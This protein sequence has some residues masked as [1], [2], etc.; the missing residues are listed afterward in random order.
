MTERT[1]GAQWGMTGG[2]ATRNEARAN[3]RLVGTT[4]HPPTR[5]LAV[6]AMEMRA[7]A[8]SERTIT[9]RIGTVTRIGVE[10]DVDPVHITTQDVA[11]FIGRPGWS[12]GTRQLRFGELRAWCRWL[13]RSGRRD[14]D[15]TAAL[16]PPRVPR[17]TP[18][19]I[20]TNQLHTILATTMR[21]KT[22]AMILLA[23]YQGMRVHEIAKVAGSDV[24]V[25]AGRLRVQGKGGVRSV[26][27]L[28]PVVADV[29]DAM[30]QGWWFPEPGGGSGHVLGQSVSKTVGDVM[31]RAGVV[32]TPHCLRH[33]HGTELVRAG[34]DLETVRR[35][36]RH[37]SLATTQ[38]Y[39]LVADEAL[40]EAVS[41]LPDLP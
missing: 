37:A 14:D 41:R 15:P 33:W 30:P 18:R 7:E 6:W 5:A 9:G 26:M 2:P 39:V 4:T 3:L 35:L 19:P 36:M 17:R 32:G 34:A 20:T 25:A 38:G 8:L 16:R 13:V 29:A 31:R 12:P 23:A 11:A 40:E 27:P 24:D 28:H 21:R 10:L 22:R 1:F